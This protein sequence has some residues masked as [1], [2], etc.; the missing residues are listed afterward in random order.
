M[1]DAQ[2]QTR[3]HA[4]ARTAGVIN[5]KLIV[6]GGFAPSIYLS[7]VEQYDPSTGQWTA[8]A[9]MSTKR[10]YPAAGGDSRTCA[11]V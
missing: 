4:Y 1:Y 9:S 2:G 5:G 6:A 7:S 8:L 3:T 10:S 11:S